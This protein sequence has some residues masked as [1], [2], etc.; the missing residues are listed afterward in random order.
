MKVTGLRKFLVLYAPDF[1]WCSVYDLLIMTEQELKYENVSEST[2]KN[3]LHRL[4]EDG[5]FITKK[6]KYRSKNNERGRI[7]VLYLRIK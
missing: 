6:T 7:G 5:F 2:F 3:A 4:K 1:C